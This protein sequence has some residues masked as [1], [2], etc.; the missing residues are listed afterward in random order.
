MKKFRIILVILTILAIILAGMYI[1]LIRSNRVGD[2]KSATLFDNMYK[3]SYRDKSNITM[4][5]SYKDENNDILILRATDNKEEK[6]ITAIKNN[7]KDRIEKDPDSKDAI[8]CTVTGKDKEI[9]YNLFPVLK[10]YNIIYDEEKETDSFDYWINDILSNFSKASY[11]TRGY[12]LVNGRLLYYE[13]FKNEGLKFYFD[14]DNL[15]YM[16][17]T[18]L[19]EAFNN[20]KDILYK[21]E[22]RY[23]DSYKEMIE[24]PDDYKGYKLEYNE[25]TAETEKIEIEK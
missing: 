5:I 9:G 18:R 20:L 12:E 8:I 15:V 19:D 17:S 1:F 4:E 16:K 10:R 3:N 14:N 24:I 13:N 21:V 11:Y 22:I 2:S 6:E 23:D 7:N 25:E